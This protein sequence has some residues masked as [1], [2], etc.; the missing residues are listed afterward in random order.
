MKLLNGS[1]FADPEQIKSRES[2][3]ENKKIQA[4]V[5]LLV[6]TSL[7]H[8]VYTKTLGRHSHC[9]SRCLLWKR[10]EFCENC[11]LRSH[12]DIECV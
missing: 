10:G 8:S 12:V 7:K 9:A 11:R 3:K 6:L 2:K 5:L 4:P 1:D